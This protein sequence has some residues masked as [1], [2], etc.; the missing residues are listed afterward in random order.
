MVYHRRRYFYTRGVVTPMNHLS[1]PPEISIQL[2]KLKEKCI[3]KLLV[4]ENNGN[5]GKN[6]KDPEV[7]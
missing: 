7:L 6:K 5:F 2:E 1:I 3:E 4:R